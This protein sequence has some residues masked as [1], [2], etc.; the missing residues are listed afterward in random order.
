VHNERRFSWYQTFVHQNLERNGIS[1][2]E[3]RQHPN[4][5]QTSI[6]AFA[7]F[8]RFQTKRE[9]QGTMGLNRNNFTLEEKL[10]LRDHAANSDQLFS[11]GN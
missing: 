9:Q 6:T 8:P 3:K 7:H 1:R 11:G 5:R 2:N 4:R 10:A